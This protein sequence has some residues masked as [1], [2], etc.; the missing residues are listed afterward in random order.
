MT[1]LQN[2]LINALIIEKANEL[3]ANKVKE[4]QAVIDAERNRQD[5]IRKDNEISDLESNLAAA[6]AQLRKKDE[7]LKMAM[8]KIG[9]LE[10]T[11]NDLW[12]AFNDAFVELSCS[13][14]KLEFEAL[15]IRAEE[16]LNKKSRQRI[17][18]QARKDSEPKKLT[19]YELDTL[20]LYRNSNYE[21]MTEAQKTKL[22]TWLEQFYFWQKRGEYAE[23]NLPPQRGKD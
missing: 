21:I 11:N 20:L 19:K 22:A 7:E 14:Q 13:Q 16:I 2:G 17:L 6:R 9:E 23:V 3:E 4:S 8:L 10:A 18:E 12:S 5:S 1:M 15:K